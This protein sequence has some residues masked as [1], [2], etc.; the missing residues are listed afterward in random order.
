[1]NFTENHRADLAEVLVNLEGVLDAILVKQNEIHECV[2][3]RRW[4]DLEENLCKIRTLSDSFVNL[5][6]KRE[7]LAGD[8]KSIYMDKNI[9]P[10]FTSVRSKLMKSKIENEALAKY[11]QSAQ[12][13]VYGVIERCTPQQRTPVYTRTGQLRKSSAPS[14][15]V[16]AVF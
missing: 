13:F 16:N 8:D 9:S 5:D 14:L 10:V 11:V 15:I 3:E 6:K 12:K 7:I 1:M 2:K 4:S